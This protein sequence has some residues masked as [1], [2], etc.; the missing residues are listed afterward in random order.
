MTPR[1]IPVSRCIVS[2]DRRGI[3]RR[4]LAVID[5]VHGDGP[6]PPISVAVMAARDRN[7]HGEFDG[8]RHAIAVN[9]QSPYPEFALIHEIGHALDYLA[10]G[11]SRQFA[12][13]SQESWL[14]PLIAR[15]RVSQSAVV[16]TE[17]AESPL[18]PPEIVAFAQYLLRPSELF[19]RAYAQYVA[20]R[21]ADDRLRVQLGVAHHRPNARRLPIQWDSTEFE[22]L[23]VVFDWLFQAQGWRA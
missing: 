14:A 15:L 12:S 9:R 18:T 4:A 20:L 1:G 10:P 21:S 11:D 7:S 17:T 3:V 13:E 8:P 16:L 6:L 2:S 5:A 22:E 23:A 19:A